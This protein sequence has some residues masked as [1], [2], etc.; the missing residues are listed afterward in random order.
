MLGFFANKGIIWK[1]TIAW[2]GWFYEQLVGLVNKIEKQHQLQGMTMEQV[3]TTLV[4]VMS[5]LLC[6][7]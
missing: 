6:S 2:Q 3:F 5:S 7:W 4:E 1:L